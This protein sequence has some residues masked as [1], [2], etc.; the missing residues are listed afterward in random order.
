ARTTE[1]VPFRPRIP[2]NFMRFF[3]DLPQIL[4]TPDSTPSKG[5]LESL[6]Y[7]FLAAGSGFF[8]RLRV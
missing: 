6:T 5:W 4:Q 1:P 2:G 8:D 3:R 7:F